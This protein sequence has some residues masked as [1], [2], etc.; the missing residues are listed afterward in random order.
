MRKRLGI[1]IFAVILSMVACSRQEEELEVVQVQ[2]DRVVY[3]T[4]EELAAASDLIVIGEYG[5]ETEQELVYEFSSEFQKDVLVDTV[6]TNQINVLKVLKG[7]VKEG[8]SLEISQRYGVLEA[9]NQLV[10]FSDMTPMSKGDRWIFFLTYGEISNTYWCTGDSDGRY[11]LPDDKISELSGQYRSA[12]EEIETLLG[13]QQII[14]SE[15]AEEMAENGDAVYAADGKSYSLTK[16]CEKEI[17]SLQSDLQDIRNQLD[18]EA[19]GVHDNHLVQMDIYCDIL[20]TYD[21]L[22]E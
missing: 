19:F 16:Q 5:Q 8:D 21:I 18:A 15:Q 6:S 13:T 1:L 9:E 4:L 20:N 3:H 17:R 11:P 2:G 12:M 14:S 7:D 10:T 22:A